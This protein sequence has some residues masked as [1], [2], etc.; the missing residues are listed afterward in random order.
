ML[1]EDAKYQG[2]LLAE[3][4][5]DRQALVESSA[6]VY[7]K[8]NAEQKTVFDTVTSAVTAYAVKD[9]PE[10]RSSENRAYLLEA[11]AGTGKTTV[12]NALLDSIRSKGRVAIPVASSGIAALLLHGGRTAH[13][14]LRIPIMCTETSMCTISKRKD[15]VAVLLRNTSLL[16][17]DE[18]PMQN[19]HI[20]ETVDR[21]LRHILSKPDNLFGGLPFL[22]C[23]DMAQI[24]PVIPRGSRAQIVMSSLTNMANWKHVQP[25]KLQ[26]NHRVFQA[27]DDEKDTKEA[28]VEYL[29]WLD[30]VGRGE[31]E[32][33]PERGTNVIRL[34]NR[35]I[36]TAQNLT[37]FVE[38]VFPGLRERMPD[39]EY[40]ACRGI[41]TPKVVDVD[42]LNQKVLDI[43]P[44][45]PH[46]AFHSADA[47]DMEHGGHLQYNLE[48][49]H[50]MTPSGM[51]PHK[52]ILK[53]GGPIML[54]RNLNARMG[55]CNGTRLI[56]NQLSDLL[57]TATIITGT[58]A[59][60]VIDIPR[61]TMSPSDKIHGVPFTRRQFPVR[62]AFA[63]TINKAQG[64]T[65]KKAG[66][67][68]PRPVFTHGQL[69][70]AIS[71]A[72]HPK[73]L[74]VYI[75]NTDN[76]AHCSDNQTGSYTSNIVYKE[77][78]RTGSHV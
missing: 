34:N 16:V 58:H 64:Q 59:G 66:V 40:F 44:G 47:V 22:I 48:V 46:P 8:L 69:Y 28:A 75:V 73:N 67:Y 15:A 19:R 11:P 52:L 29:A 33:Y 62:L 39:A 21:T 20:Y 36:S 49:L 77:V 57:I 10:A 31:V 60:T 5:Y 61:I 74:C 1:T 38:T 37:E 2:E 30:K 78:F 72:G 7:A 50:S 3:T 63:F 42:T 23:G 54:L 41:L 18:A 45:E 56:I 27:F 4:Q 65:L 9:K 25:L 35:T 51:P 71:R 17:W 32:S 26:I 13:S 12:L 76:P 14:R 55:A 24:L 6:K 68:L 70:V 43:F 53:V